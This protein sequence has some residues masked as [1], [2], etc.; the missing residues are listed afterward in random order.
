MRDVKKPLRGAY[1]TALVGISVPIYDKFVPQSNTSDTFVVV[2]NQTDLEVNFTKCG[3]DH[4]PTVVLDIV[5]RTTEQGGSRFCDDVADEILPI[6]T[7]SALAI[8]GFEVKDSRLVG[9]DDLSEY[10]STLK[11]YRRILRFQ[12]TVK[13]I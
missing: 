8:P 1:V 2:M 12:H 7:E 3:S 13:E 9:D 11:V 10:T 6:I 4:Q 5:H